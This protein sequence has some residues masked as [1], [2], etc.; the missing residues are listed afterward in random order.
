MGLRQGG[1]LQRP[2]H[3]LREHR[4]RGPPGI[5]HVSRRRLLVRSRRA[6]DGEKKLHGR[7]AAARLC[8]ISLR[9]QLALPLS[10]TLTDTNS[11]TRWRPRA[12]MALIA[13]SG[14]AYKKW[15]TSLRR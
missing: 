7:R 3:R 9:A 14:R 4:K 11:D 2:V 10:V 1:P 8:R 15:A 6:L 12:A 5:S 13:G